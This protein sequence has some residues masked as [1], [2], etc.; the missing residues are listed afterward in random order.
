MSD[1]MTILTCYDPGKIATKT[2]VV[3]EDGRIT[4]RDYKA[5]SNFEYEERAVSCLEDIKAILCDLQHQSQKFV[6]RGRSKSNIGKVVRR[7]E[8][9][10]GS[11]FDSTSHR[12]VMLDTDKLSYD[13][14]LDIIKNPVEVV[15]SI[16]KG[17]PEPFR[18]AHCVFKFSSSQNI[19]EKI[20]DLPKKI[21]SA[22]LWFWCDKFISDDEW[23][24]YF[25]ANSCK[26]DL[27]VFTPVQPHYTA[28]PIFEG[29][30]D[31]VP[32]R[33]GIC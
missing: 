19:P 6:I 3:L 7:R 31:P 29:M 30:S 18:K 20:G 21:V 23:K 13:D 11:A 15:K 4:K 33:I 2:F 9:G 1:S 22:H 14:N 8:H 12:W 24:R 25:R 16:K 17:L 32:E 26:V 27:A 10:E 5:G 28:N